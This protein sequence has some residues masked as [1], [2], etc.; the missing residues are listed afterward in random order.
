MDEETA[1]LVRNKR[2]GQQT[3]EQKKQLFFP[4]DD[5][6]I[7]EVRPLIKLSSYE[8][9]IVRGKNGEDQVR[10]VLDQSRFSL[11]STKPSLHLLREEVIS[12]PVEFLSQLF[13]SGPA[14]EE[15]DVRF[16]GWGK[17]VW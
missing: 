12:G 11:S 8:A 16:E 15:I 4:A 10:G 13:D 2:T 6:E 5:E 3:L 14:F 9:C 17:W 7:M 1:V